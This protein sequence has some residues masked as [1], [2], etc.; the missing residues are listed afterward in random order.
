[1]ETRRQGHIAK[2][3]MRNSC[4]R[5]FA[6]KGCEALRYVIQ[7]ILLLIVWLD[8]SLHIAA[9]SDVDVA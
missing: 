8:H 3:D 2:T 6:M 5:P 1:M 7:S 9:P 4:A